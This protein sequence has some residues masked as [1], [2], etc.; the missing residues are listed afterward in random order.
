MQSCLC[1]SDIVSTGPVGVDNVVSVQ[2]QMDDDCP[3][4]GRIYV[5]VHSEKF[6]SQP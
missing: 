6:K 5:I 2:I 1:V 4:P 3:E